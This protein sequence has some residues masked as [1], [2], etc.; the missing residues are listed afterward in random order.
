MAHSSKIN[1]RRVILGGLLAGAILDTLEG[2]ATHVLVGN[3][4]AEEMKALGKSMQP[5]PGA[6]TFFLSLGFLL[7]LATIWLYAA[8]R[9]PLVR[10]RRLPSTPR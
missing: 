9:P 10:D 5:T 4:F 8:I 2:A 7:G 3:R 1:W 6:L